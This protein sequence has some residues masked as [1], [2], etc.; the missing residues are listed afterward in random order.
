VEGEFKDFG[1]GTKVASQRGRMINRDGS[2]NVERRGV[3]FLDRFSF[4]HT[5]I[6]TSW[7]LGGGYG[8]TS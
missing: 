8:E 6:R 7:C 1:L 3:A 4:F 5:L 2:F